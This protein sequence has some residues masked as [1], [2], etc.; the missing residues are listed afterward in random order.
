LAES[1]KIEAEAGDL[2]SEVLKTLVNRPLKAPSVDLT[3]LKITEKARDNLA[4]TLLSE[5]NIREKLFKAVLR[6]ENAEIELHN[7][8]FRNSQSGSILRDDYRRRDKLRTSIGFIFAN[9][10]QSYQRSEVSMTFLFLF[11]PS[12]VC[13]CPCTSADFCD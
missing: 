12:C 10:C 3:R 7:R 2:A 8:V 4:K 5:K 6:L 11:F 9:L 13:H 1:T